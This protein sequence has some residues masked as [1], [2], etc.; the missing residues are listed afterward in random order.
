MYFL[1][2]FFNQAAEV[3]KELFARH[4]LYD[5]AMVC[6]FYPNVIFQVREKL[7][8]KE[9]NTDTIQYNTILRSWLI[10]LFKGNYMVGV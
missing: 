1:S 5:K 4:H 3:L 2:T 6:S 7:C 10:S 9:K 8:D